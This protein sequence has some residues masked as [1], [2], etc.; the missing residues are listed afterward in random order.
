[1]YVV[2][3]N[4]VHLESQLELTRALWIMVR[5]PVQLMSEITVRILFF[6]KKL[7][8]NGMEGLKSGGKPECETRNTDTL[9]IVLKY[10]YNGV[11]SHFSCMHS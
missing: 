8:A 6:F 2:R 5:N 10:L 7:K 11:K 4:H 1:M 3:N 9:P